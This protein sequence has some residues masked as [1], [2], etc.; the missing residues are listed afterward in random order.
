MPTSRRISRATPRGVSELL[1]PPAH[2]LHLH[3]PG[4][5]AGHAPN[6]AVGRR[7][8]G[9][10]R[11]RARRAGRAAVGA[12]LVL[13][14]WLHAE[15]APTILVY[16]HYDVQPVDPIELWETA[17]FEP[18]VRDGRVVGR[19]AADDKGQLH[20]HLKAA[21]AMLATRG[22]LPLNLKFIFEGEEEHS[23]VGLE[24]GSPPRVSASRRR[25]RHQRHGLLRGQ[26][27][28]DHHV[29]PGHAVHPDRASSGRP[30]TCTRGATAAPSRTPPTR[31]PRS[32][33]RSRRRTGASRSRASTTTS[34]T[35]RPGALR[36]RCLPWTSPSSSARP[37]WPSWSLSDRAN[38]R[39][40]S[41]S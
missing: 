9:A 38:S 25:G 11:V 27:P 20:M 17:P 34:S 31:W 16:C 1:R 33:P 13:G 22:K 10:E 4:A 32:S 36:D 41:K 8:A 30:S 19:G 2:P 40:N 24:S 26:H 37:A 28:R 12:P 29:A 35:P 18:F 14:D 3:A 23:S 21:E 6:R 39:R 5:R 7:R 15:G